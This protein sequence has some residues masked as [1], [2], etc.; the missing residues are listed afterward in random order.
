MSLFWNDLLYRWQ[1]LSVCDRHG[2]IHTQLAMALPINYVRTSE[3]HPYNPSYPDLLDQRGPPIDTLIAS[4]NDNVLTYAYAY[5][6]VISYP[7][8][9]TFMIV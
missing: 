1:S 4:N 8:Y 5:T 3:T 9:V 6:L 2:L 7:V